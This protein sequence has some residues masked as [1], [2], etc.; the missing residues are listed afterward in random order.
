MQAAA[1]VNE[2]PLARGVTHV[3][4]TLREG[5]RAPFEVGHEGWNVRA[6]YYVSPRYFDA[7]GTP[8]VAGRNLTE[9]DNL[10]DATPVVVINQAFA[11]EFFP[12]ENPIGRKL[13]LWPHD[14]WCAIVGVAQD[15]KNGG[16]GDNQLWLSK[17]AF[18]SIYLAHGAL[19]A[20]LYEPPWNMGRTMHLSVRTRGD[21][22]ALAAALRRTVWSVDPNQPVVDVKTMEQ[23]VMDSVASRRLGLWPLGT[24]ALVALGLAVVGVFGLVACGVAQR[25]REIGIRVALGA[26]GGQMIWMIVSDSMRLALI[27]LALGGLGSY[28]FSQVLANQLFSIT[29]TDPATYAVVAVVLLAAVAVASYVPVRRATTVDPITVLRC[30]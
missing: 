15:M 28:Y 7:M 11:R 29:A 30:D 23:R 18:A 24:F 3:S 6:L 17:P 26:T 9:Q 5:L 27:G 12:S 4:F 21:P 16:L 25:T 14:I 13:R 1:V 22:S 2:L 19:P 10:P 8:I 20:R